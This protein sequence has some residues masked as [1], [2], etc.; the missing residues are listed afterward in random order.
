MKLHHAKDIVYVQIVYAV[1]T[2]HSAIPLKPRGALQHWHVVVDCS[3]MAW[4]NGIAQLQVR[5]VQLLLQISCL[6]EAHF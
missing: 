3:A 1:S 6:P 2:D 4:C 5:L